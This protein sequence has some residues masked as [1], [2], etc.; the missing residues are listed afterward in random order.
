MSETNAPALTP[1]QIAEYG[2]LKGLMGKVFGDKKA[3]VEFEKVAKMVNPDAVTTEETLA[4]YLDPIKAELKE[5]KALKA[6]IDESRETYARERALDKLRG[7]GYTEEGVKA[8]EKIMS[9]KGIRDAEDAAAV[10]DKTA[11]APTSMQSN[12]QPSHVDIMNT[13]AQ[14]SDKQKALWSNPNKFFE[15]EAVRIDHEFRNNR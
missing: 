3:R 11:P 9:D 12:L 13:I 8:I 14:D 1:E 6:E 4:P 2:Q 5:A 15:D 7:R 10:F